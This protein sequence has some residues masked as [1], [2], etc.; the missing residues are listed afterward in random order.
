MIV[1]DKNSLKE[2]CEDVSLFEAGEIIQKLEQEL[3][4]SKEPGI[5][6]AS[7]QIGINKKICIIRT[8]DNSLDLVNPK[9]IAEHDIMEFSNEGCLSFPGQFILTKRFNE[10]V[11]QDLLHPAGIVCTGLDAV[12]V[13]HEVGHLYGETMFDYQITRP[14]RN[15]KCWCGSEKKYKICHLGQ[16]IRI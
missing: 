12:V 6:L 5:G 14:Q 10:I 9:I 3:L 15:Q 7:I 4:Q 11:V 16:E 13:A 8:K 1:I 2:V